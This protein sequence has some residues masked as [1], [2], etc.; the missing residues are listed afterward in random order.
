MHALAAF[1]LGMYAIQKL[2]EWLNAMT[3]KHET[4]KVYAHQNDPNLPDYCSEI[5]VEE[6]ERTEPDIA[7]MQESHR[8]S[9]MK[10]TFN[11]LSSMQK[12]ACATKNKS[13]E[14]LSYV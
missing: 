7:C 1:F 8:A 6:G 4:W 5:L 2:F 13:K 14:V 12:Y 3:V 9:Y 10:F 11:I